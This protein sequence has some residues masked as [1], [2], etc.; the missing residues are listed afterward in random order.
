MA[1][2]R[3]PLYRV[4]IQG[5]QGRRVVELFPATL[6]P[7]GSGLADR[8]RVRV[9]R[10]WHMPGGEKY[11]FMLLAEALAVAGWSCPEPPRPELARGCRRRFRP[12]RCVGPHEAVVVE[13]DPFLG[14]D[15]RWRVFVL[16]RREPVLVDD[17]ER[18]APIP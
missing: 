9:D 8:Y 18:C 4:A 6:F 17:L 12:G 13:T 15:G 5:P 2:C 16:G 11:V 7:G 10:T 3:K 1:E 14:P